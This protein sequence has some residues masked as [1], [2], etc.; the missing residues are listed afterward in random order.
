ML[1]FQNVQIFV[2]DF[3]TFYKK[4]LKMSLI[5]EIF[6]Q[7]FSWIPT[8]D[9]L[10][11]YNLWLHF[12]ARFGKQ[13]DGDNFGI[14]KF[15]KSLLEVNRAAWL[16]KPMEN[17]QRAKTE[18]YIWIFADQYHLLFSQFLCYFM[19]N[20]NEIGIMKNKLA[21]LGSMIGWLCSTNP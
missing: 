3:C 6:L 12:S 2:T 21:R 4:S 15:K 10:P 11:A 9:Y 20:C 14:R 19:K 1:K 8:A 5:F 13:Q 18:K 7:P 17:E 16:G